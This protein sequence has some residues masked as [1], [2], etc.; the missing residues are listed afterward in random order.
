MPLGFKVPTDIG[1]QQKVD[2]T[3]A[4]IYQH[5]TE[6]EQARAE[7]YPDVL[8]IRKVEDEEEVEEVEEQYFPTG[9][10]LTLNLD[11]LSVAQ[12]AQ[13][14]ALCSTWTRHTSGA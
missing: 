7:D 10:P 14:R 8:V 9:R 3:L 12:Q 4:F 11:H 5:A 6:E 1:N 2:S 13:V